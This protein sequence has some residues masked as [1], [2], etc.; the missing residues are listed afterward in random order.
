MSYL[1]IGGA[2]SGDTVNLGACNPGR[3]QSQ[4]GPKVAIQFRYSR[5]HD[6]LAESPRDSNVSNSEDPGYVFFA[7]RCYVT[8]K[9]VCSDQKQKTAGG[10]STCE[11]SRRKKSCP[12]E[13]KTV[14]HSGVY[15]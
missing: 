2:Q 3:L 6:G 8:L 4:H 14:S 5:R 10:G 15:L 11:A 1:N 7:G 12:G 9:A 13:R